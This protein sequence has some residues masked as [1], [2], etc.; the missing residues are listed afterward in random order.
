MITLI[1]KAIYFSKSELYQIITDVGGQWNDAKERPIVC[2]IKSTEHE[3]LFWAIPIG[4]WNHRDIQGQERITRYMSYP[5][6]DLRSCFYHIG[7]TNIKSIFFISDVIP[8][9]DKYIE[10]EYMV[11]QHQY[12]IR[13]PALIQPLEQKLKRILAFEST[14]NNYFRQRITDVKQRL[15]AELEIE[16]SYR[17][18]APSNEENI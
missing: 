11:G 13:N 14:K 18:V 1:E 4:N 12:Q 17:Q 6:D 2:L 8:I 16:A 9:I 5:E 3:N 7:R 15:L 10:R